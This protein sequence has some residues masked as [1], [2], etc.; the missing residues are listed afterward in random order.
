MLMCS[1][2]GTTLLATVYGFPISS[3]EAN[4]PYPLCEEVVFFSSYL[5]YIN[6]SYAYLTLQTSSDQ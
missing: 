2:G 4:I 3:T 6:V 5:L 1:A